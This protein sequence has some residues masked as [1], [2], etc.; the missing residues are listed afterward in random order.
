[1]SAISAI[2]SQVNKVVSLDFAF[3][4]ALELV[5]RSSQLVLA[6]GKEE[7]KEPAG[8]EVFGVEPG[9]SLNPL[10]AKHITSKLI[11]LYVVHELP[12]EQ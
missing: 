2:F 6:A 1:M 9:A 11:T 3:V 12:S 4:F 8:F 5:A 10:P 7:P